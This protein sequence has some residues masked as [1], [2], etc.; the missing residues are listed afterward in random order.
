MRLKYV[1]YKPNI[2]TIWYIISNNIFDKIG[3]S[4]YPRKCFQ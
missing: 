4:K 2:Y 3:M 1:G